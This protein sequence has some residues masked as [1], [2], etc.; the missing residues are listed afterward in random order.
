MAHP[1]NDNTPILVSSIDH[2][3]PGQALRLNQPHRKFGSCYA[4]FVAHA[5]NGK[6]VLVRKLISGMY[7][8]RWTKPIRVDRALVTEVHTSMARVA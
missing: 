2:A 6:H 8:G 5:G 1:A 3:I 4:E 7:R